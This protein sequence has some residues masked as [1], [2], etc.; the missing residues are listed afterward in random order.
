MHSLARVVVTRFARAVLTIWIVLTVTFFLLRAGGDPVRMMLPE[1]A[2]Q[3]Q[4]D[5]FREALGLDQPVPIQYARYIE[6]MARGDFGESFRFRTP[7]LDLIMRRLPITVLI[8]LI[9]FTCIMLF[10]L[11]MGTLTALARGSRFDRATSIMFGLLQSAPAFFSGIMLI[12]IFSVR[13]G[14]LPTSGSGSVK[15]LVLPA[16]TISL[17]PMAGLS[18]L[19]R[20]SLLEI[21]RS[22][23]IR[24][25]RSKGLSE[26]RIWWTHALRNASLPIATSSGLLLAGLLTG[27]VIVE[28]VFAI[29]GLGRLSVE[30][31]AANDFPL[32]QATVLIFSLLF[33]GINFIVD[34]SYQFLDPRL[35]E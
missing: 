4:I 10:G 32:V 29:P 1:D 6:H 2:S 21:L 3:E 15:Q 28:T 9:A 19:T 27:A 35:A 13:L 17:A 23:Y 20:S 24:T 5:G 31:V 14:W 11:T 12:L 18:R 25:A 7:V 34:V 16:I 30:A 22:D 26:R 33:V 8:A